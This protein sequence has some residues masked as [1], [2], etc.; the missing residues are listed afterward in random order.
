MLTAVLSAEATAYQPADILWACFSAFPYA[1]VLAELPV[2]FVFNINSIK[3]NVYSATYS[4]YNS[5]C[6][7]ILS[8]LEH[9]KLPHSF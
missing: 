9:R 1:N 3:P 2:Q 5:A 8:V 4:F 7:G 6:L